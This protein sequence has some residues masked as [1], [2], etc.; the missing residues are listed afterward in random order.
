M[1]SFL[2]LHFSLY[3]NDLPD[4]ICNI[5]IYSDDTTLYSKYDQACDLWKQLEMASKLESD[6]RDTVDWARKWLVNFNA[7]KTQLVSINRCNNTSAIDVKMDWSVLDENSFL[8]CWGWLSLLN[9]IGV[10]TLSL[11]LKLPPRKLEPWFILWSFFLLRCLCTFIN[12]AYSHAWNTVVTSELV[13]LGATRNCWIS[14]KNEYAGLLILH[15]LPLFKPW[16][17]DEMWPS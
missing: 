8:R 6:L 13:L 4:V 16:L 11:L 15:L 5:A 12:L 14:Y 2:V 7:G 10:L 1:A 3:I 17:I 9:W